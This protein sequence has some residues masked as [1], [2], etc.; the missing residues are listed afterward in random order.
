L[1]FHNIKSQKSDIRVLFQEIDEQPSNE[2]ARIAVARHGEHR[3][4]KKKE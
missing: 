4:K 3:S 1:F 2:D